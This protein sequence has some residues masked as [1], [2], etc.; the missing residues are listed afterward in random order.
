[1]FCFPLGYASFKVKALAVAAQLSGP[2]S[3]D[4]IQQG[5]NLGQK[6]TEVEHFSGAELLEE[7]Y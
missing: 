2:V 4:I 5:E 3:S 6:T 7:R 1:M